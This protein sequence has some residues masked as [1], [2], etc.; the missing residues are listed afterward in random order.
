MIFIQYTYVHLRIYLSEMNGAS[1]PHIS[2]TVNQRSV[3]VYP[4][5]CRR[6]AVVPIAILKHHTYISG[7]YYHIHP[8]ILLAICLAHLRYLSAACPRRTKDHEWAYQ[9]HSH[10][11]VSP[12]VVPAAV[13]RVHTYLL[14]TCCCRTCCRSLLTES[15]AVVLVLGVGF[16]LAQDSNYS[17]SHIIC[18]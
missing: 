10:S 6:T 16:T 14:R 5:L 9:T 7:K 15:A 17:T 12:S 8:S 4:A 11:S 3:G 2:T 18:T 13:V 1:W